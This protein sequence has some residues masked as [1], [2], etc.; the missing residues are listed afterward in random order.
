MEKRRHRSFITPNQDPV[1]IRR[2]EQER[3]C[4]VHN[5]ADPRV[6]DGA[7][8]TCGSLSSTSV[9]STTRLQLHNN[10]LALYFVS[11]EKKNAS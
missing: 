8:F 6:A 7:D 5:A 2:T 9:A 11:L 1:V 10:K 4:S 3:L